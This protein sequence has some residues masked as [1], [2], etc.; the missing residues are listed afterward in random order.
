M[1]NIKPIHVSTILWT[2]LQK[3][4]HSPNTNFTIKLQLFMHVKIL[5]WTA[6][7]SLLL[8]IMVQKYKRMIFVHINVYLNT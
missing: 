5:T 6:S 2:C 4:G 7:Y 8:S 1:H 3:C